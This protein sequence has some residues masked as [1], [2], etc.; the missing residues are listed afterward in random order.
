[1]PQS[2]HVSYNL[3]HDDTYIRSSIETA[4]TTYHT[5]SKKKKNKKS[6][7]FMHSY[8][9]NTLTFIDEAAAQ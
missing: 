8:V 1:M 9:K 2:V 5:A 7:A 6:K 4:I 3:Y